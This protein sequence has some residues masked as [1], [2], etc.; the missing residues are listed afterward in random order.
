MSPGQVTERHVPR[1]SPCMFSRRALLACGSRLLGAAYF[2][3]TCGRIH[4]TVIRAAPPVASAEARDQL[5]ELHQ[6]GDSEERSA[7][8]D[9]D[10]GIRYDGVR[11]LRWDGANGLG[12]DLQ[13]EPLAVPVV[14]LGDAGQLPPAEW[15]ERMRHAHKTRGSIRSICISDRVTS[16]SRGDGSRRCG[17]RMAPRR[18]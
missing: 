14:S 13:Q 17:A 10:L 6:V 4:L 1:S 12:V 9:G 11:P 5:R 15:V 2:L 18:G 8:P 16:G 3:Y 7:L